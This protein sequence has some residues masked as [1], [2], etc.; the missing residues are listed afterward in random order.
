M[1]NF[2]W[3]TPMGK[4]WP[5]DVK[6]W[7][8]W[9][10]PYAGKD[11]RQE[12]KGMTEDKMVGWHHQLDVHEFE[13]DLGVGYGQG[14]LVCCSPWGHKELDTTELLNCTEPTCLLWNLFAGQEATVKTGCRTI[15]WFLI[16]KRIHQGCILPHCL[17]NLYAKYIIWN[18]RLDEAQAGIKIAGRNINNLTYADDTTLWKKVKN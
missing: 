15:D 17:F 8:I 18:S 11:W 9:T 12:D 14:S 6:K 5:P 4:F 7:L 3:E 13:Q 16:R 10:D 1:G 2:R